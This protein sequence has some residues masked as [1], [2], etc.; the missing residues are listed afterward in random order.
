MGQNYQDSVSRE[1]KPDRAVNKKLTTTD[2]GL[3][4]T[5]EKHLNEEFAIALDISPDEVVSYIR[6]HIS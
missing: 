1:K 2:E 6:K 5:A 4:N 3:L